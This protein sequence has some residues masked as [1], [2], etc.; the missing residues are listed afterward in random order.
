MKKKTALIILGVVLGICVLC[1]IVSGLWLA[2]QANSPEFKAT[3]T[4]A[5]EYTSP[6]CTNVNAC[7]T[8]KY[9]RTTL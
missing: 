1:S 2:A 6:H 3:H 5:Y 8:H 7:P 4:A 9:P